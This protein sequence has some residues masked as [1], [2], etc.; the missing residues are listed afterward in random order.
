M[1]ATPFT[2]LILSAFIVIVLFGIYAATSAPKKNGDHPQILF[3]IVLIF[4]AWIIA[5][6]KIFPN[7]DAGAYH[8]MPIL[9]PTTY[10]IMF[11]VLLYIYRKQYIWLSTKV[12][13]M[14]LL[15]YAIT[16]GC[17]IVYYVLYARFAFTY[18]IAERSE[19][20]CVKQ[21]LEKETARW[22]L[23]QYS[24][25]TP[26]IYMVF[27]SLGVLVI[28]ITG[29]ITICS[30]YYN[31]L[32]TYILPGIALVMVFGF[33][34]GNILKNAIHTTQAPA[35]YFTAIQGIATFLYSC[36]EQKVDEQVKFEPLKTSILR[37]IQSYHNIVQPSDAER[38]YRELLASPENIDIVGYLRL[39]KDQYDYLLL[40]NLANDVI[41]G[42][43][44]TPTNT[45]DTSS[46]EYDLSRARTDVLKKA[47]AEFDKLSFTSDDTDMDVAAS[48]PTVFDPAM[49]FANVQRSVIKFM[50]ACMF[51]LSFF[52]FHVLYKEMNMNV[53]IPIA[54][55]T[56]FALITWQYTIDLST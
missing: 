27:A 15:A 29:Y 18:H 12:P 52:L 9:V 44:E 4:Y 2:L 10:V 53:V 31:N 51:V 47:L 55:I 42:A 49:A 17:C 8:G 32:Q 37:N 46:T 56:V 16:I 48:T 34:L 54:I 13:H 50:I 28:T 45:D 23:R 1:E 22:N 24:I 30:I 11:F 35:G 14:M 19:K 43:S 6:Q 41:M 3:G 40:K 39:S 25:M 33:L 7:A 20:M 36:H 5:Y 26:T 38:I 21:P